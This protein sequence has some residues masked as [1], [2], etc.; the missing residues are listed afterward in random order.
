MFHSYGA[1]MS[2][3]GKLPDAVIRATA[4]TTG[5]LL[6]TRNTRDFPPD[7]PWVREPCTLQETCSAR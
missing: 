2:S 4:Q 1:S 6:V 5:R 7:D 3:P